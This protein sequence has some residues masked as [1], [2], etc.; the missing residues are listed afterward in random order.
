VLFGAHFPG[1]PPVIALDDGNPVPPFDPSLT[2]ETPS[3]PTQARDSV[4]VDTTDPANTHGFPNIVTVTVAAP[5]GTTLHFFCIF[6]DWM[7]G[8]I[9]VR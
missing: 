4:L 1:G 2:F 7:H 8:T 9:K 5:A 6:H 3:T